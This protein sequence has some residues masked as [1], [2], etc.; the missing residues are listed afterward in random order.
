MSGHTAEQPLLL[1]DACCLINLLATGRLEEILGTLPYRMATSRL[2]ATEEVLSIGINDDLEAPL[3]REIVSMARLE[4]SGSLSILELTTEAE[5]AGFVHFAAGLDDG[6]ASICAL[7][8]CRK[9]IVATD[10]RKA[11]RLLSREVPAIPVLQTSEL[12]YQWA[13][14]TGA[15]PNLILSVLRAVRTRARFYPRRDAPRCEW[16]DSYFP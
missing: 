7:A 10:D 11:L 16:W 12:L 14:L 6:E 4:S 2:V 3:E 1:L 13:Y 9:A 5:K 15:S 8:V